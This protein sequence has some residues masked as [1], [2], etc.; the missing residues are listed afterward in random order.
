MIYYTEIVLFLQQILAYLANL[1]F[2]KFYVSLSE[3][4]EKDQGLGS[5]SHLHNP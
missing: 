2:F 4:F 3:N 1:I 5:L